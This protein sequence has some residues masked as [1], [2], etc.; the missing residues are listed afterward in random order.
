MFHDNCYS[1]WFEILQVGEKK[2]H[3]LFY[4][5]NRPLFK[6]QNLLNQVNSFK[7]YI[8]FIKNAQA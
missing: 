6:I 4:D 3:D 5:I 7:K 2:L 8:I 1:Q